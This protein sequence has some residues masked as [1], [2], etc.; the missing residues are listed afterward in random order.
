MP[1]LVELLSDNV[2]RTV[3]DKTGFI[4]M[5]NFQLNFAPGDAVG[6]SPGPVPAGDPEKLPASADLPTIF[7]ALQEQLGLRLRSAKGPIQVLVIDHVERP[8]GN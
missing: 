6:N 8:S 2:G 3:I 5:F 4:G 7:S 1:K